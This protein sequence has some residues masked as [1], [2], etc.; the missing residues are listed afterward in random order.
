[1]RE[2]PLDGLLDAVPELRLRQPAELVVDLRRVDRIAHIVP[3]AVGNERDEALRLAQLLTDELDDID[4]PHLVVPADVV[5]LPHAPFV[6]D[7]VDRLAV[8]LHIQP[9]THVLALAV[10]GQRLIVERVRDHKRNELLGELIRT[11]VVRATADGHGK[12]VCSM[13]GKH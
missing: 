7:E 2:V 6:D 10:H 8:I 5:H 12:S 3:F 4:V 1:M 9:I 13:V 11:I